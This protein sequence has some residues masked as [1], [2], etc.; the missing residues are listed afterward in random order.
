MAH[1]DSGCYVAH[2]G[3]IACAAIHTGHR[4]RSGGSVQRIEVHFVLSMPV[5][6]TEKCRGYCSSFLEVRRL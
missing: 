3:S 4:L 1:R 5:L 6:I 2:V